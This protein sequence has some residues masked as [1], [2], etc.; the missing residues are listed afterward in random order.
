M[1]RWLPYLAGA[2][3]LFGVGTSHAVTILFNDFSSTSGLTLNG[4]AAQA[5]NVLRV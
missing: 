5:G 1:N 3:A 4:N 2:C